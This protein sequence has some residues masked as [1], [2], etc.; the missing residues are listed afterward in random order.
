MVQQ[1]GKGSTGTYV[2]TNHAILK[3]RQYGL[4]ES[5][6]KR[7][8]RFPARIEEGIAENTIAAM[9][10]AEA[11]KYHEIWVMYQFSGNIEKTEAEKLRCIALNQKPKVK[12]ITAWRYPG[13]SKERDP[14][15][16]DIINEVRSL[17]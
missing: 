11:K 7:V 9:Q 2:W 8:I 1:K 10:P 12:I 16:Q 13:K 3:M 15:P 5:R 4:T 6:I 17:L 14:I